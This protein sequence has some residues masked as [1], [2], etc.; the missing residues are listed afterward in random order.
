M[1][2]TGKTKLARFRELSTGANSTTSAMPFTTRISWQLPFSRA[3]PIPVLPFAPCCGRA[4][5]AWPKFQRPRADDKELFPRHTRA[6]VVKNFL[7]L[8]PFMLGH[9]WQ[10]AAARSALI[11]FFCFSLS[12]RPPIW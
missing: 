11:A 4:A 7:V 10:L 1:N 6:Q 9:K 2:L 5:F 3:W 8:L 12:R